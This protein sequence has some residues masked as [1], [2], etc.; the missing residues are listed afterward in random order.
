MEDGTFDL[1]PQMDLYK[2]KIRLLVKNYA[3]EVGLN[4]AGS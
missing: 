1:H 2:T 4:I 3:T